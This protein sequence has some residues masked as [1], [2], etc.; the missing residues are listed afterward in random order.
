MSDAKD[1]LAESSWKGKKLDQVINLVMQQMAVTGA[2]T[3]TVE[4]RPIETVSNQSHRLGLVLHA[5]L[6]SSATYRA[7]AS[8]GTIEISWFSDC[9]RE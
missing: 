3:I 7:L 8:D 4:R 9:D 1:L 2:E 5:L 6:K